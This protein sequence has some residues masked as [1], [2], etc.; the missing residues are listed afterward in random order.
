MLLRYQMT[1]AAHAVSVRVQ[2]INSNKTCTII[3]KVIVTV[4]VPTKQ[5]VNSAAGMAAVNMEVAVNA[6]TVAIVATVTVNVKVVVAT[7]IA[8]Q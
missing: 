2:A 7:V 1:V 6:G 5:I 8:E 4:A 3:N